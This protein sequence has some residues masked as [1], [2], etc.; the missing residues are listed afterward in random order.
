MAGRAAE[1]VRSTHQ[2]PGPRGAPD[3]A[4]RLLQLAPG[5]TRKQ[6]RQAYHRLALTV[7]PDSSAEHTDGKA[8]KQL[9]DAYNLLLSYVSARLEAIGAREEAADAEAQAQERELEILEA[10][11]AEREARFAEEMAG[12]AVEAVEARRAAE[13]QKR[14]EHL[15]RGNAA[16]HRKKR[17]Q[18]AEARA[19]NHAR[20]FGVDVMQFKAAYNEADMDA[21]PA[22]NVS[23]GR[24]CGEHLAGEHYLHRVLPPGSNRFDP[25]AMEWSNEDKSMRIHSCDWKDP[26]SGQRIKA[27]RLDVK[28]GVPTGLSFVLIPYAHVFTHPYN[29]RGFRRDAVQYA[30]WVKLELS[31]RP[32]YGMDPGIKCRAVGDNELQEKKREKRKEEEREQKRL[33]LQAKEKAREEAN[34]AEKERERQ[35]KAEKLRQQEALAAEKQALAKAKACEH[36]PARQPPPPAPPPR[37]GPEGAPFG[38]RPSQIGRSSR[39]TAGGTRRRRPRRA[40]CSTSSTTWA[41][42]PSTSPSRCATSRRRRRPS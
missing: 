13:E 24:L 10:E 20:S 19:W 34:E 37:C 3:D 23:L 33:A 36:P 1:L 16:D 2:A 5:A 41:R 31:G 29:S 6:I 26:S 21:P 35:E 4:Y 32:M 7:H 14:R 9:N 8:F 15:Q 42:A 22:V 11:R 25:F 38:S 12:L 30:Y 39:R 17:R 40:R 27:R 28:G 18:Q